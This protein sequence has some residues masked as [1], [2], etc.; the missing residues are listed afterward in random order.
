MESEII[1]GLFTLFGTLL[2]FLTNYGIERVKTKLDKQNYVSKAR[3]DAEFQLY[4]E[5]CSEYSEMV[6][7]VNELVPCEEVFP[8]QTQKEEKEFEVKWGK[9]LSQNNKSVRKILNSNIPFTKKEIYSSFYEI[10]QLSEQ[11]LEAFLSRFDINTGNWIEG[12]EEISIE[13]RERTNDL[14]DKY[15]KT[16]EKIY[17]YLRTIDVL[18]DK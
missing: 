1:V 5:L 7:S 6:N 16:C 8:F 12:K 14:N 17:D 4:Q 11:Q 10:L 9:Q 15:Q 2:G 3:F 18:E 13:D